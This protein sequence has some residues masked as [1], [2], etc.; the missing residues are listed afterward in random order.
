MADTFD[1]A[2]LDYLI[3]QNPEFE[4]PKVYNIG[5]QRYRKQKIRVCDKIQDTTSNDSSQS[6]THQSK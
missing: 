1:I 5:L 2:N 6:W 4:I 3:S